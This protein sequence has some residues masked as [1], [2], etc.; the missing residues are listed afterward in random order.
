[1]WDKIKLL[2]KYEL[3][4]FKLL[5]DLLV[6]LTLFFFVLVV[7]DGILPG[8]ISN[9]YDPATVVLLVLANILLI[10]FL[11]KKIGLKL[12][13][14]SNKKTAIFL[15]FVLILLVS[16][17]FFHLNIWLNIFL[18]LLSFLIGYFIYK[19]FSEE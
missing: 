10:S 3:I 8:I 14:K 18:T 5:N 13:Q 11:E 16:N 12:E 4:I 9:Y 19:V 2:N 15:L 17:T 1:M 7:A 6:L